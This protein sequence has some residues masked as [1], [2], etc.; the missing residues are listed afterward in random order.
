M[1][2]WG[3]CFSYLFFFFSFIMMPLE[4]ILVVMTKKYKTAQFFGRVVFIQVLL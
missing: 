3:V 4:C 2:F 1:T